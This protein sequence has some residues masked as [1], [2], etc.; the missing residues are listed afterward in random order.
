D[1]LR[2]ARRRDGS[3]AAGGAARRLGNLLRERPAHR[4]RRSP[5][6][7]PQYP[8]EASADFR[9]RRHDDDR[10]QEGGLTMLARIAERFTAQPAAPAGRVLDG[11]SLTYGELARRVGALTMRLQA[12]AAGL[13]K[14][15]LTVGLYLPNSPTWVVADLALLFGGHLEVPVPIGFT[16]EQ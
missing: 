15:S 7:A 5:G 4:L 2:P 13:G 12:L 8:V 9:R 16:A 6:V 11:P 10:Q 3:G 14:E 1:G